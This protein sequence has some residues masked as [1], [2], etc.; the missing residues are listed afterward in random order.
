MSKIHAP[1]SSQISFN[2]AVRHAVC[3]RTPHRADPSPC[4]AISVCPP[5]VGLDNGGSIIPTSPE[6]TNVASVCN[7]EREAWFVDDDA[8]NTAVANAA[9]LAD[10]D[11]RA[12][13]ARTAANT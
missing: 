8:Y 6:L 13:T 11:A 5:S 4:P 1:L 7:E 3:G 12:A 2:F 10:A 9:A